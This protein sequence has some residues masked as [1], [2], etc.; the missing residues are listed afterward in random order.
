MVQSRLL[1]LHNLRRRL[2]S[3]LVSRILQQGSQNRRSPTRR[4]NCANK[5]LLKLR[6]SML[7]PL[8]LQHLQYLQ[9][10]SMSPRWLMLPGYL[11]MAALAMAAN[12]VSTLPLHLNSPL[13]PTT[14]LCT[15]PR[16]RLSLLTSPRIIVTIH[17]LLT[18][19]LTVPN[20][21]MFHRRPV[22]RRHRLLPTRGSK[23]RHLHPHHRLQWICLIRRT[24]QHQVKRSRV[25][26]I[27]TAFDESRG[28][29]IEKIDSQLQPKPSES[30]ACEITTNWPKAEPSKPTACQTTTNRPKAKRT[31]P[32]TSLEE[33]QSGI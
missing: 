16:L 13:H 31:G 5:R 12:M 32:Q 23:S 18:G 19:R 4:R 24:D 10:P 14:T 15:I 29:E 1:Q 17:I 33:P 27:R 8:R 25:K 6:V 21:I 11:A 26:T 30:T 20:M 2:L 28:E 7:R 22:R 9:L 3:L